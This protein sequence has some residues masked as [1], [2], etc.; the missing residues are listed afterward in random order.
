MPSKAAEKIKRKY[1]YFFGGEHTEG[2]ADMRNL[3]GGK[4]ANLAE[5]SSLGINVPPGFTVT[6]E[7]CIRYF[8]SSHKFPP[9][10]WSEVEEH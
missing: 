6:T 8:N 3:L 1:V 2:K 9:G 7:A 4:G 10:M 5:M